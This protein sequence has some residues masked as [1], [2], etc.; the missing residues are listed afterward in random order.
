MHLDE[1]HEDAVREL[2]NMAMGQ[3]GA[4]L[5][6][7]MDRYV[8]LSIPVVHVLTADRLIEAVAP[9]DWAKRH[10]TVVREAFFG[11]LKGESLTLLDM[12]VDGHD[13]LG[14]DH[15]L[16]RQEVSLELANMM[17]G[18]CLDSIGG[19]LGYD[20]GY[21]P[22]QMVRQGKPAEQA[23]MDTRLDSRDEL[24]VITFDL[25]V[26]GSAFSS[27]VV[28]VLASDAALHFTA[29]VDRF[30]AAVPR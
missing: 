27:R 21:S 29:A 4:L 22:P 13:V 18:A 19:Q 14:A 16:S 30:L 2:T 11:V 17:T 1:E 5:A 20:V 3:A 23:L 15:G 26:E 10:V 7:A 12:N 6:K 9:A 24:L 28:L 25:T 8:H